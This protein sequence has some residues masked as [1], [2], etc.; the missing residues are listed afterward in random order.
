MNKLQEKFIRIK[1]KNM[2]LSYLRKENKE[3]FL[4]R[5]NFAAM[6]DCEFSKEEKI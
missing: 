3:R 4:K 2:F 1:G 5:C 6:L